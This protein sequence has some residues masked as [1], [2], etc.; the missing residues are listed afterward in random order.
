MMTEKSQINQTA[1]E[2]LGRLGKVNEGLRKERQEV[3]ERAAN[4]EFERVRLQE[5]ISECQ[6]NL[7]TSETEK[8]SLK[9][10]YSRL[11]KE[12]D[13]LK[14]KLQEL[15]ATNEKLVAAAQQLPSAPSPNAMSDNTPP[16]M[17]PMNVEPQQQ[18]SGVSLDAQL[19]MKRSTL[20]FELE[21]HRLQREYELGMLKQLRQTFS[22]L[23]TLTGLTNSALNDTMK[24]IDHVL[25]K[26]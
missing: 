21:S 10:N 11:E 24:Q 23:Q 20:E 7:A 5:E 12:H 9:E 4:A 6:Q 26:K 2:E 16:P 13:V 17:E 8:L 15:E 19:G 18:F 14:Q 3:S 1:L 25:S 22:S